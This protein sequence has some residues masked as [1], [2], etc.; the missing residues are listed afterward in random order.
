[1]LQKLKTITK[2]LI[3]DKA[4]LD[5]PPQIGANVLT[6]IRLHISLHRLM[7][8]QIRCNTLRKSLD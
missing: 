2:R 6:Q 5:M 8:Q 3:P 4:M 1:M 7:E